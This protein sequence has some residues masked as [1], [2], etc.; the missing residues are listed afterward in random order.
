MIGPLSNNLLHD[1]N[2]IGQSLIG[3][4][5]GLIFSTKIFVFLKLMSKFF[6]EKSQEACIIKINLFPNVIRFNLQRCMIRAWSV[7]LST[8]ILMESV[9]W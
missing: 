9:G 8:A 2:A 4:L 7:I 6:S 1:L 5:Q 3:K